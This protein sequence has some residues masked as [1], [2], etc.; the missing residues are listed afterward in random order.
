[1][2]PTG[3][4]SDLFAEFSVTEDPDF[5]G[6]FDS[7]EQRAV[8]A[9]PQVIQAAWKANDPEMFAR[10]F[11]EGGSLLMQQDQLTSREEIRSYMARGFRGG[12]R[13]ARVTGWPLNVTF[14]G[15]GVAVVVTQGGIILD[16]ESGI[17]PE[18]EIRA[19]WTIVAEDGRW[20]L[21]CHHGTP[22][23]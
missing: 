8:L 19:L 14:L 11:A 10:V 3:T 4:V 16:G 9:V 21:L 15:E 17:A 22:L 20:R 6:S 23:R 12:L 7:A 5:Y 13:G 1:M 18:R 2:T